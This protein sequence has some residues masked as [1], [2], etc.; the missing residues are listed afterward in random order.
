MRKKI[1]S[2]AAFLLSA[3][4]NALVYNAYLMC[5]NGFHIVVCL[6]DGIYLLVYIALSLF[7]QYVLF[8]FFVIGLLTMCYFCHCFA[9]FI[10]FINQV[11]FFVLCSYC[12]CLLKGYVSSG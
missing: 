9:L 10:V 2:I 3:Y 4:L 12:L 6:Y 5:F 8:S 1:E 11:L 7:M